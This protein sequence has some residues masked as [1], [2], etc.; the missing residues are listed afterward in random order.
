M[1]IIVQQQANTIEHEFTKMEVIVPELQRAFILDI[2]LSAIIDRSPT[3]D[4]RA[5]DF[6]VIAAV[7]YAA[8]KI[9]PRKLAADLWTRSLSVTLPLQ[10]PN[11]WLEA[12]DALAG[13]LSF[14]TGDAWSFV[15]TQADQ[16][17]HRPGA[18][19]RKR[20]KGFPESPCVSLFSGGLDSFIAALDVLGEQSHAPVMLVSH[21]DRH[22]SGPASDQESLRIF[23]ESK[24]PGRIYHLQVRVGV[25]CKESADKFN[26]ETSFRSR[27]LIFLGLA[28]YVATKV[29]EGVPV[30]IPE[31]GPIA[32]NLPLNP[33]R[34][35]ACSTRTA[36]PFFLDSIQKALGLTGITNRILNPYAFKTK[37]EMIRECRFPDLLREA[38]PLTNSC[39]RAGRKTHWANRKAKACG[40]CVPCLF[41][42]ASLHVID[43]DDE[44]FGNDVFK[45]L[46][47]NY[48]DFFAL[49]GL[50][51]QNPSVREIS[52]A[53][54]ANGRLPILE[55][56]RHG[57]VVRRM[58]DE[59]TRWIADQGSTK[60]CRLAGIRKNESG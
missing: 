21:Y 31:N 57:S 50:L 32:L 10:E 22:V 59:V 49:L 33:S 36:H 53:L 1:E 4:I 20:P 38:Y 23:L 60:I 15:F 55:L 17:F 48:P 43:K 28:L 9:I 37:G 7:S 27:S 19:R 45:S 6:L 46:P 56:D 52:R 34:R 8:D 40:A 54:L 14:L 29:G 47:Q 18:N 3:F 30:I 24:F 5:L 25:T 12:G 44:I 42:R 11:T 51:R 26:F 35:G 16:P 39:G 2:D 13:S 41:R 58:L